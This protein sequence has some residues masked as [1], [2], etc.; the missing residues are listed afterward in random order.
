MGLTYDTPIDWKSTNWWRNRDLEER[1]FHAK[2]PNRYAIENR[3]PG[4]WHDPAIKEI[5][6]WIASYKPGESILITGESMSGKTYQAV[7]ILTALMSNSKMSGRF[8]DSDDYIEMVKDSFGS[9]DG[10]PHWYST[11]HLL[12]YIKGVWDVVIIDG[13]GQERLTE[14]AKHEIGSLIRHRHSHM[15][16]TIIT[17]EHTA[18]DIRHKYGRR[19]D[20]PTGDMK[21]VTLNGG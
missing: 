5:D 18:A 16:T 11:P 4:P 20:G 21:Q 10:L 7:N 1:M 13:L 14:F 6:K 15:L 12:K 9:D 2:I 17:S 19:L 3:K 8:I